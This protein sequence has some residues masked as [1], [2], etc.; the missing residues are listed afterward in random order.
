L[1]IG[2]A[3]SGSILIDDYLSLL[4]PAGEG[5]H[6]EHSYCDKTDAEKFHH[7]LNVAMQESARHPRSIT[8]LIWIKS[9]QR[10]HTGIANQ[11]RM[12]PLIN[13]IATRGRL[14]DL[15]AQDGGVHSGYDCGVHAFGNSSPRTTK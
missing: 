5:S 11:L 7:H 8:K 13:R 1:L 9:L 3:G 2:S 12:I 14:Y 15:F 6:Q 4:P 10:N